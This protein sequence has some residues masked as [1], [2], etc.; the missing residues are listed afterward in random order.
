MSQD[1]RQLILAAFAQARRSGKLNWRR[2]SIAVL[3]N[4]MLILTQN[5]FTEAN[6]GAATFSDFLRQHLEILS[7]DRTTYPPTVELREGVTTGDA[8]DDARPIA[9]PWCV[10]SD[11]WNAIIDYRS[12]SRYVWDEAAGIAVPVTSTES[13]SR[14]LPTVSPS[15]LKEWR[16]LFAATHEPALEE[17]EREHL[18]VWRESL[19]ISRPRRVPRLG[20]EAAYRLSLG[21]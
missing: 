5:K 7:V 16:D 6:Y 9:R 14:V 10:R 12:G 15:E 20:P 19:G 17:S 2:M 4:R 11:L 3:K 21:C 1:A 13:G 8:L 18:R